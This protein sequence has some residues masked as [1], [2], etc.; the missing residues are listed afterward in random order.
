MTDTPVTRPTLLLRVRDSDD[1]E[2]WTEFVQLYAPVIRG[3]AR[4]RGL[5]PADAADVLQDVLVS[6][7]RAIDSFDYQPQSGRFR[8]WLY[9]VT[10][11]AVF[12]WFTARKQRPL[13]TGDSEFHQLLQQTGQP[14]ESD[15][16][17][18]DWQQRVFEWAV[19]RAESN[20]E[21]STWQAFW[22]V[23]VE[24][25]SPGQVAGKLGISVG[26]V[27]IAKSRVTARIRREIEE[28]GDD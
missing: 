8:A 6:V 2:A 27:Y 7:S 11:H 23:A 12:D 1:S 9:T 28:L 20:F 17:E 14:D 19:E 24:G 18:H 10:R 25:R 21:P 5:Q 16:W 13:A 22:Q 4:R 15:L 3:Y 26:A